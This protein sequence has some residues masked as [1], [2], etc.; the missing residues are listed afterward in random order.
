MFWPTLEVRQVTLN[1]LNI[2]AFKSET[3]LVCKIA[4]YPIYHF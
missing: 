2:L 1:V 3:F 4:N